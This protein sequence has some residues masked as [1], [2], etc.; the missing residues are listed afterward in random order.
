ME[1]KNEKLN[2]AATVISKIMEVFHW[3]A[4]GLLAAGLAAYFIDEK[5]LH[6]FIDIGN[7]E[8]TVAGYSIHVL[9][10]AGGLITAAFVAALIVG[11]IVCGLTAMI[12]RNIYLIF[13]TA[14]GKTKFSKGPTPFQS[15]NVRM[16]RE[17][18][19]FAISIPII[20]WLCDTIVKLFVEADLVESSVSV[21]GIVLGIVLL[22]LSQFFAYGTQLQSDSD[23][24]L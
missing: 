4:V 6:Y 10:N 14:A 9:D 15:D 22:C 18:G 17:I 24:L 2:K 19:I 7:G 21:T 3:V 11:I 8:F 20:E 12:F 13:K 1:N 16:L 23:G 5:L